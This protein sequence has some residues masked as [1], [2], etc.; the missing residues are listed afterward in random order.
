VLGCRA[1]SEDAVE[2]IRSGLQALPIKTPEQARAISELLY[3][4]VSH[5][6]GEHPPV[7]AVA[8]QTDAVSMGY[9]IEKEDELLTAISM[10]DVH[11]ANALLNDIFGQILFHSGGDMEILRSRVVELTVL[12]SRAALKGGA[13]IDAIFG[14]NYSY[15]R[16]IDALSSPEDIVLWLHS[17]TRRFAQHVFDYANS[18][19]VDIIYKAIAYIK[20]KFAD[21]I[22]LQDVADHVFLSPSYF[23]KVFKEET[24]QT[25]SGFITTVRIEASKKLLKDSSV[26]IIDI[27]ELIG[28]ESQ[29]YFTQVFKKAEGCTPGRYRQRIH[30]RDKNE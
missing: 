16:E 7:Q 19:H 12:L 25:P 3:A 11:T 20:Q 15:L 1:I 5:H 6:S 29:S 17:V 18:K 9:S 21:K 4:C 23:S 14:L 8:T 28:F 27:P 13:S 10:G 22:S 24:G 26:N 30:K 2:A